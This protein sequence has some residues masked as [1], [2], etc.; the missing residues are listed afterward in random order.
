M[1]YLASDNNCQKLSAHAIFPNLP[2]LAPKLG[3]LDLARDVGLYLMVR[4]H[5]RLRALRHELGSA[6]LVS[7]ATGGA[8]DA[9]GVVYARILNPGRQG[10]Q[11]AR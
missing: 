5:D 7:P 1:V 2:M 11:F 8:M 3:A 6:A 9:R 4:A 10:E